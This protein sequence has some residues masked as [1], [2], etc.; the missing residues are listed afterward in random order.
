MHTKDLKTNYAP[1]AMVN[2]Q[3]A[4]RTWPRPHPHAANI[5]RGLVWDQHYRHSHPQCE[6]GMPRSFELRTDIAPDRLQAVEDWLRAE[7][8]AYRHQQRRWRTWTRPDRPGEGLRPDGNEE[9]ED[10]NA[11]PSGASINVSM[12]DMIEKKFP[13]PGSERRLQGSSSASLAKEKRSAGDEKRDR[14]WREYQESLAAEAAQGAKGGTP[15]PS[16]Q[17]ANGGHHP[18]STTLGDYIRVA[19]QTKAKPRALLLKPQQASTVPSSD[20]ESAH[21][22]RLPADQATSSS[23]VAPDRDVARACERVCGVPCN[24]RVARQRSRQHSAAPEGAVSI[25]QEEAAE[26]A[27]GMAIHAQTVAAIAAGLTAVAAHGAATAQV[28]GESAA[29]DEEARLTQE[30]IACR[31]A[32]VRALEEALA[33]ERA[34]KEAAERAHTEATARAQADAAKKEAIEAARRKVA[35]EKAKTEAELAALE[36]Q[37]ARLQRAREA[38]AAR[39]REEAEVR[40]AAATAAA[41]EEAEAKLRRETPPAGSRVETLRKLFEG[42]ASSRMTLDEAD[43]GSSGS[44]GPTARRRRKGKGKTPERPRRP[45]GGHPHDSDPFF[46]ASDGDERGRRHRQ[47]VAWT[48]GGGGDV[49]MEPE[50]EDEDLPPPY[51]SSEPSETETPRWGDMDEDDDMDFGITRKRPSSDPPRR[52]GGDPPGTPCRRT[53]RTPWRTPTEWTP[54]RRTTG[55]GR[56]PWTGRTRQRPSWRTPWGPA[57]PPGNGAPDTTWRWIVYL[58]RRVQLLELEVDTGKGE[59]ARISRVAARA[60]K[61]LDIARAETKSLTNVVSGLQQ[62]L[63]ALEARGSVGSDHPPLE[64]GS[65]DDGWGPGPGP[66]RPHAPGGAPRSRPSASAPSLTAPSHHSAGRR[67]ERVPPGTGSEDW[68][69]EWLSAEHCNRCAPPRAPVRPRRP[70]PAPEPIF[71]AG[72][73]YGGLRD[74]VPRGDVEWDVGEGEDLDLDLEE[75]DISPPRGVRREAAERSRQ[76]R[77]EDAYMEAVR[78]RLG[79]MEEPRRSHRDSMEEMDVAA[80]GV[81]GRRRWEPRSTLRPAFMVSKAADAA[82]WEDLKDIKPPMYDSNPLNLDRFLEKLDD[83]GLT[84]SEDLPPADAERYVF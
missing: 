81:R 20:V 54:W 14:K 23:S 25:A 28:N 42:D 63:D 71:I 29:A 61:E 38:E 66:G 77:D 7:G 60:Q 59:M 49:P 41:M 21:R 24:L 55:R 78:T 73:R 58:R 2:W 56:T 46:T 37:K 74:E 10:P 83:W 32:E 33:Q 84:V 19:R 72:G 34:K 17:R 50:G 68:R 75:C 16:P 53:I 44:S 47:V 18:G 22:G 1:A 27:H 48:G 57:D 80:V 45:A 52:P 3:E 26:W 82:V 5:L 64:S 70:A 4:G 67:N 6:G 76:R 15:A 30:A 9:D 36:A 11:Y 79:Y 69:D 40:A 62:R 31:E 51:R 39:A 8:F 65:S 12:W 43:T 13:E 35:E